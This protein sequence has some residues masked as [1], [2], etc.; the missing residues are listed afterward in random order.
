MSFQPTAETILNELRS[1]LSHVDEAQFRQLVSGITSAERL[2]VTGQG[3]SGLMARA[4]AMR[5]MHVGIRAHV[6]GEV[7]TP[8]IGKG[9]LLLAC[10]ASGKT[11]L[12]CQI[13]RAAKKAGARVAA[14][15]ARPSSPLAKTAHTVAVLHAP[16]GARSKPKVTSAQFGNTL[17]EQALLVLLD[18]VALALAEILRTGQAEMS[19]RHAN[20]E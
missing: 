2:F 5:A 20:L 6:V 15:V 3:R 7:T 11:S 16:P 17:F 9:D 1:V 8:S 19:Q 4:F 10:S 13:A 14:V 12:T 18:A